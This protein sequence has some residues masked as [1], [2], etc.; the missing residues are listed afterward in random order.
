MNIVRSHTQVSSYNCSCIHN[1]FGSFFCNRSRNCKSY[2]L[3]T[4]RT[5]CNSGVYTNNLTPQIDKR[6]TTVSRIDGCV[7]MEKIFVDKREYERND[8]RPPFAADYACRNG[9][10]APKRATKGDNPI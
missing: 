1:V 3:E 9:L 2:T 5:S 8:M 4:T 6:A 7:R 10:L